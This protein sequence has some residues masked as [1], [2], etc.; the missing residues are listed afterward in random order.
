MGMMGGVAIFRLVARLFILS[1]TTACFKSSDFALLLA[2]QTSIL[3]SGPLVDAVL[4]RPLVQHSGGRSSVF[5]PI[6]FVCALAI[7]VVSIS[8]VL[9]WMFLSLQGAVLWEIACCS[10]AVVLA[11]CSIIWSS[12]LR[13]NF[14]RQMNYSVVA[15]SELIGFCIGPIVVGG[16]LAVSLHSPVLMPIG[17]SMQFVAQSIFLAYSYRL[18]VKQ[19]TKV[20][21]SIPLQSIMSSLRSRC[22]AIFFGAFDDLALLVFFP[23]EISGLL[24]R[25]TNLVNAPYSILGTMLCRPSVAAISMAKRQRDQSYLAILLM[26]NALA[27][28]MLVLIALI[29][30]APL[31]ISLILN[32][33]VGSTIHLY[34]L[35]VSCFPAKLF[36]RCF[37]ELNQV[38][39][40]GWCLVSAAL[41][42]LVAVAVVQWFNLSDGTAA[43]SVFLAFVSANAVVF[44]FVPLGDQRRRHFESSGKIIDRLLIAY[45]GAVVG[46]TSIVTPAGHSALLCVIAVAAVLGP[47]GY[48]FW[49]DRRFSRIHGAGVIVRYLSLLRLQFTWNSSTC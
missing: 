25:I 14:E 17:F 3:L 34:L 41:L 26:A 4:T 16:V 48:L 38:Y 9:S 24:S 44:T 32:Q 23:P 35:L 13:A 18:Q 19:S 10:F 15:W 39:N 28:G 20:R 27:C 45:I 36:C 11:N 42:S 33:S 40:T 43:A 7:L 29:I 5:P 12:A 21:V 8:S 47:I 1:L 30:A 49:S 2:T 22:G 37:L 46:V 6:G 31:V